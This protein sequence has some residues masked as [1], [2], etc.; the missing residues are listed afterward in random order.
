MSE[1]TDDDDVASAHTPIQA[2]TAP[3][4]ASQP[5]TP[6]PRSY[7]ST[8]DGRG[9]LQEDLMLSSPPW[10]SQKRK[11][12]NSTDDEDNEQRLHGMD[13]GHR[14]LAERSRGRG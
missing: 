9:I 6:P 3:L 14:E 7:A 8:E 12:V 10:S 13:H 5:S 1:D 4:N 2:D 11:R